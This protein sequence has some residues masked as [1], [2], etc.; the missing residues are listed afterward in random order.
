[1]KEE[2]FSKIEPKVAVG[3]IVLQDDKMY[4][5]SKVDG[6]QIAHKI[7]IKDP[8]EETY[9]ELT[10]KYIITGFPVEFLEK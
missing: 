8:Y 3:F 7:E 2:V 5:I 10:G 9:T 6:N 1:M 4:L